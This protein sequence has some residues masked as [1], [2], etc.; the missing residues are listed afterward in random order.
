MSLD[1]ETADSLVHEALL[2]ARLKHRSIVQVHEFTR[3]EGRLL[4]VME[5]VDGPTLSTRL[6]EASQGLPVA[7]VADILLQIAKGLAH[8][9]ALTDPA[10]VSL[11]LVHR[12]LKPSNVLIDRF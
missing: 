10:G 3:H 1:G 6:S 8:A 11:G 2:G 9:H 4:M 7:E 5:L 12:D